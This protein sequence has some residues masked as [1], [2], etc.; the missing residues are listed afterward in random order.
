MSLSYP[1]VTLLLCL[2]IAKGA[3]VL[4]D[5]KLIN[6]RV[7]YGED[8]SCLNI[9]YHIH[10]MDTNPI[11]SS[12]IILL[13]PKTTF[14]NFNVK[15]LKY[16][17]GNYIFS[18]QGKA[19]FSIDDYI[20]NFQVT[21][22]MDEISSF[23]LSNFPI[24]CK[25]PDNILLEK[26]MF[27]ISKPT[28]SNNII[29]FDVVIDKIKTKYRPQSDSVTTSV[30]SDF[31]KVTVSGKEIYGI[32]SLYRVSVIPSISKLMESQYFQVTFQFDSFPSTITFYLLNPFDIKKKHNEKPLL[33]ASNP[34]VYP[35]S[36]NQTI[37]DDN[38][39]VVIYEVKSKFSNSF[40]AYTTKNNH[41]IT[42][43]PDRPITFIPAYSTPD[44]KYFV[45]MLS[46]NDSLQGN[47]I[48]NVSYLQEKDGVVVLENEPLLYDFTKRRK[49]PWL[50]VV[51]MISDTTLNMGLIEF[52]IE[53]VDILRSPK[54]LDFSGKVSP[55]T[56]PYGFIGSKM[57]GILYSTSQISPLS[58]LP[59]N[60]SINSDNLHN[61]YSS[62]Y[63]SPSNMLIDDLHNYYLGSFLS[64][65]N[66]LL[67]M[68]LLRLLL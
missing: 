51:K 21:N 60:Y 20:L 50:P 45:G 44:A 33:V 15:L 23:L 59:R 65:S 28:Y 39:V 53:D 61:Y 31:S 29:Q 22:D 19:L 37:Y 30:T 41:F 27:E 62:S 43:Y 57:N 4:K 63:L 16:N 35:F 46:I 64:P 42:S 9:E 3:T 47:N 6:D 55:F 24:S 52:L 32:D 26:S 58:L 5:Y 40:L 56:F 36:F 68:F 48:F 13:N 12:N 38:T 7:Y 8:E 1:F 11:F 66:K 54:I 67:M 34:K 25:R 10:L 14:E 18:I 17:S 2:S 49:L